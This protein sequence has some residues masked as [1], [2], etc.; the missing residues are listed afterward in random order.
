MVT[1]N[2]QDRIIS[3]CTAYDDGWLMQASLKRPTVED[4]RDCSIPGQELN[5]QGECVIR[6]A[7]GII[8]LIGGLVALVPS[9]IINHYLEDDA[10]RW[11]FLCIWIIFAAGLYLLI[12]NVKWLHWQIVLDKSGITLGQTLFEWENIQSTFIISIRTSRGDT[13]IFVILDGEEQLTK[14]DLGL[15]IWQ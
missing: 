3:E 8:L 12:R 14:Y 2:L 10:M 1:E 6:M 9:F 15:V 4:T 5:Y 13:S 7:T 11:P